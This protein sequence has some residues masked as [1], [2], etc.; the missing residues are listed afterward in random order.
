MIV[1]AFSGAARTLET[2]G[3][4]EIISAK[5]PLVNALGGS[6]RGSAESESAMLILWICCVIKYC[7]YCRMLQE[8]PEVIFDH[9]SSFP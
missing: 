7:E 9:F 4:D 2:A 1:G 3:K 6:R 8:M 5:R